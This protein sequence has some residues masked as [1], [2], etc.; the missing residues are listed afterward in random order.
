VYCRSPYGWSAGS[1]RTGSAGATSYNL[2]LSSGSGS[3]L[4][5]S[6]AS[7]G[8]VLQGLTAGTTYFISIEAVNAGGKSPSYTFQWSTAK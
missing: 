2:Y 6:T 8:Y 5:G 4:V 1:R 7:I 3:K